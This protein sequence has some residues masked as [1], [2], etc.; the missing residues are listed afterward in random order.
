MEK[1]SNTVDAK[2]FI[3]EEMPRVISEFKKDINGLGPLANLSREE[4]NAFIR[5]NFPD[6][7]NE[8]VKT[9]MKEDAA[10]E[11]QHRRIVIGTL[12]YDG[13]MH[14]KH[15]FDLLQA[16]FAA[17]RAGWELSFVLR[18]GD[19]M[20]ARGR[21]V[22]VAKF[23]EDEKNT[24]LFLID[25]DLSFSVD[26]FIRMCNHPVDVVAG[27]YPYKDDAGQFPLRWPLDGLYEQ[28]G[29]WEV[30]AVTPGFLRLTRNCLLKMTRQLGHL[31]YTD[32]ALGIG[33]KS[34]M[35][36]DNAC[37]QT[38]VYDE[39]YIF[40]EY[41]HQLGGKVWLDPKCR[42]SHM[43]Y[44]AYDHGTI[45]DWLTRTAENVKKLKSEYPNIPDLDLVTFCTAAKLNM[46]E[47]EKRYG[48]TAGELPPVTQGLDD[49]NKR[50]DTGMMN[51]VLERVAEVTP[52][53]I[54]G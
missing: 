42:I 7:L 24:D 15:A 34:W 43:G 29:L 41:W 23:L 38:G 10:K 26:D 46:T 45:T 53:V 31:Q 49:P 12:S 2:F 9:D 22:L 20:V 6:A 39:G 17:A 36:F 54:G 1:D 51:A 8:S 5:E 30:Q 27:A 44:K 40:C 37:R 25:T 11:T 13:K 14:C 48:S 35:L 47:V 33:K 3:S 28:G 21:N 18:E 52:P 50:L 19:S 32:N 4:L 16:S